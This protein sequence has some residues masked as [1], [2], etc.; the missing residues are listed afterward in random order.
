MIRDKITILLD[1]VREVHR[2]TPS[3]RAQR[4]RLEN[5][6]VYP[7]LRFGEERPSIEN[8]PEDELM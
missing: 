8:S 2:N 5:H 4:E 6:L 1:P 7:R 3:T